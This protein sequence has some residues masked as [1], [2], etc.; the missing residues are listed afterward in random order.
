MT[1]P[2]E[3][4]IERAVN[5]LKRGYARALKTV[6]IL[7]GG[8]NELERSRAEEGSVENE[9]LR[10][11]LDSAAGRLDA[12]VDSW[13]LEVKGAWNTYRILEELSGQKEHDVGK[14]KTLRDLCDES[15]QLAK[16]LLCYSLAHLRS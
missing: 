10:V 2:V 4:E 14:L 1:N 9:A 11:E 5:S 15:E 6:K 12:F 8:I 16:D 7:K 3:L 13:I